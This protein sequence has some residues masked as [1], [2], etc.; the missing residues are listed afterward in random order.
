MLARGVKLGPKLWR[1]SF[2]SKG[3]GCKTV[4]CKNHCQQRPAEPS[5]STAALPAKREWGMVGCRQGFACKGFVCNGSFAA[6]GFVRKRLEPGCFVCKGFGAKAEVRQ[7]AAG[8]DGLAPRGLVV[9]P[10]ERQVARV[11]KGSSGRT[12]PSPSHGPAI[13]SDQQTVRNPAISSYT[14]VFAFASLALASCRVGM[15]MEKGERQR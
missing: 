4:A 9:K 11:P 10:A 5:N 2:V 14:G 6:N 1:Q 7:G 3:F 13:V 12:G 15:V 8:E